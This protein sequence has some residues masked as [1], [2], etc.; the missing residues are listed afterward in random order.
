MQLDPR[1]TGSPPQRIEPTGFFSGIKIRPIIV[2]VVV[3]YIATYAGMYAY[4]FGYL[5]KELSKEGEIS[6]DTIAEYMMTTE[7]LLIGFAIGALGT[8]IGGFVAARKAGQ[9]EI[10]HGG[11]VGFCSLIISFIEEAMREEGVPLPDWFRLLSV[12]AIVP[13]G[14]LGGYVAE[15][16]KGIGG[17]YRASNGKWPRT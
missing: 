15:M 2:G 13:A 5:A 4:F 16:F 1:R 3:D 14:M 7:G 8:A 6:S 9:L 12:L 10:K 17:S 11:L